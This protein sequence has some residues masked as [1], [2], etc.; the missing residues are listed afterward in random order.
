MK[1]GELCNRDVVT[2]TRDMSIQEAALLMREHHVGCL[3]VVEEVSGHT[4]PTGILTDRDIVIEVIAKDVP[5]TGVTVGDVMTFTLLKVVEDENIFDVAQ[6][7]RC[8]G[9]RRVPVISNNGELAGII[10]LDD[11]LMM[12][13]QELSLL[14]TITTREAEQE[15][16]KRSAPC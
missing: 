5:S 12:L 14:A 9:V 3:I 10:A 15:V 6:R 11:L 2:A 8:R 7:M 13:S 16:T 1:A 4:R